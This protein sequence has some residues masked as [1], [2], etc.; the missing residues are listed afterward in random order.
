MNKLK[1][2]IL[3]ILTIHAF[4]TSAQ[5]SY[6]EYYKLRNA[7]ISTNDTKVKNSLFPKLITYELPIREI[8]LLKKS[9][10][11]KTNKREI[12]RKLKIRKRRPYE[13]HYEKKL[14]ELFDAD[15]K[16]RKLSEKD[17]LRNEKMKNVDSL[18]K[19]SLKALIDK[20]G[21]PNYELVGEKSIKYF[22]V[23]MNHYVYDTSW[24]TVDKINHYFDTGCIDAFWAMWAIDKHLILYEKVEFSFFNLFFK[25]VEKMEPNP[26]IIEERRS[27][28]GFNKHI[29]LSNN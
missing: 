24:V 25:S 1:H 14:K 20:Y 18:N 26:S 2:L 7:Y 17:T 9:T 23:L 27:R 6:F 10:K 3:I 21:Y 16:V 15:Q 28:Y 29:I 12:K 22:G 4:I 8:K 11:S 5:I 19:I 13:T